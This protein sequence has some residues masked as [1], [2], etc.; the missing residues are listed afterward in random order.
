M[1]IPIRYRSTPPQNWT[2]AMAEPLIRGETPVSMQA[3]DVRLGQLGDRGL[4]RP[5]LMEILCVM[6]GGLHATHRIVGQG[7]EVPFTR[8]PSA[9]HPLRQFLAFA[10]SHTLGVHIAPVSF[11]RELTTAGP[12]SLTALPD[13]EPFLFVN[14]LAEGRRTLAR[15]LPWRRPGAFGAALVFDGL[16]GSGQRFESSAVA[17]PDAIVRTI[18]HQ[19]AFSY[20]L[21]TMTRLAAALRAKPEVLK[22]FGD[23]LFPPQLGPGVADMRHQKAESLIR[24]HLNDGEPARRFVEVLRDLRPPNPRFMDVPFRYI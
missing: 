23:A 17:G 2:V 13:A 15:N 22:T 12:G 16:I 19:E 7:L 1:P 6:P 8:V 10:V 18:F 14:L 3:L 20:D 5:S 21:D 4:R 9:S 11:P 24:D